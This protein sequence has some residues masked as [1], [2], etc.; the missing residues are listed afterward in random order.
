MA[1]VTCTLHT[2]E[3]GQDEYQAT[4]RQ[5]SNIS[6]I[7]LSN[8]SVYSSYPSKIKARSS[9]LLLKKCFLHTEATFKESVSF[10]E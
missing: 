9:P 5:H 1:A 3:C 2:E 6:K 8:H 7:K 10:T 4:M